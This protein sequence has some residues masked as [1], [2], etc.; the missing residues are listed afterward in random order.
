M[1]GFHM[2]RA[3]A[4][5]GALL[6]AG[7]VPAPARAAD[8]D[9]V[10]PEVGKPL[11][12]AEALYKAR[13]HRDA[14]QKVDEADAVSGKTAYENYIIERTRGSIAAAAGDH[15]K[16]ARAF[17]AVIATGRASGAEQLKLMQAVAGLHYHARD[18]AK[19]AQWAQR[20]Q[21]DGGSDSSVRT[22]LIQS[23]FLLND[24]ASVSRAVGDGDNGRRSSEQELQ[25]LA[26]CYS[27]QKDDSG[28]VS[29][30]ERLVTHYPKKEYWTD[31]LNRVQRK[32]GFS[33]RLSLDVYRLK[34]ET[35]NLVSA[36]DYLEMAQLSLQAGFPAEAKKV[37]DR[38]YSEKALGV[39][40]EAER[41]QRLRDLVTKTLGES[42]KA[43]ARIENDALEDKSGDALVNVGYS[44]VMEGAPQKGLAFMERGIK[45]GGLRRADDAKLLLGVAQLKSGAKSRG[46]QTLK[47][48]HG[49]D[50][51]AD[52]ARLW[53]LIGQRGA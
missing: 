28:Y 30:I 38:G 41:H 23:Y 42:A 47:D 51:T 20:Y 50:G 6:L 52:L 48:I 8:A 34:L 16:A 37:V 36:N 17:E 46:L 27:K 29:A 18:Y 19:A 39:G 49:K 22:V 15:T 1:I 11:Q 35:G 43:R 45:R 7:A 31:L 44:Y 13:K 12:A 3:G 14:L 2:L 4:F 26:N 53:I 5:A 25:I 40:K 9:T 10:R 21:K 33:S 32:N 24:C